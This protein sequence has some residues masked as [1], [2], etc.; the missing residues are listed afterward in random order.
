MVL[1][2]PWNGPGGGSG[3]GPGVVLGWSWGGLRVVL[4]ILGEGT[5]VL[6]M[7]WVVMGVVL[8]WSW[9]GPGGSHG[10]VLGCRWEILV[11]PEG[12]LGVILMGII[13]FVLF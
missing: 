9:G 11:D 5:C 6:G 1:G 2:L 10:V 13:I 8:G 4:V 12:V 7:Q 3:G